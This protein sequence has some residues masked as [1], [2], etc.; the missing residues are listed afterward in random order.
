MV[1]NAPA[2]RRRGL[3]P[4]VGKIPWRKWQPTPVFLP[5]EF[6]GQRSQAGYSPW[7]CEE[8]DMTEQLNN[9]K[10]ITTCVH[11]P[12]EFQGATQSVL[13]GWRQAELVLVL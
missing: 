13:A 4:W 8:S 3:D 10:N 2:I 7:G 1:K 9:N 6:H 5:G 11:S 12:A